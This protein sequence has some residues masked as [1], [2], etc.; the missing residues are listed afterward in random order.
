MKQRKQRNNNNKRKQS[1]VTYEP[2]ELVDCPDG[3]IFYWT[4][5]ATTNGQLA[6]SGRYFQRP[7]RGRYIKVSPESG[8]LYKIIDINGELFEIIHAKLKKVLDKPAQV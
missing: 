1:F 3:M 8:P 6:E 5:W 2:G 7:P 4:Q